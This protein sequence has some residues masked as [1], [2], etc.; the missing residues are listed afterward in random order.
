MKPTGHVALAQFRQNFRLAFDNH[1]GR[2]LPAAGAVLRAMPI[3]QPTTPREVARK[4]RRAGKPCHT[5]SARLLLL[6]MVEEGLVVP[7]GEI[8][9]K[10]NDVPF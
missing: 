9:F 4:L 8:S 1:S 10:R 6:A 2:K 7:V 5:G 3:T